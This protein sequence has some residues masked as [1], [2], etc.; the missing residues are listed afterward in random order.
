MLS[1]N[2]ERFQLSYPRFLAYS[3]LNSA[4]PFFC[5]PVNRIKQRLLS[6]IAIKYVQLSLT[7]ECQ[8][9]CSHCGVS[10]YSKANN[11]LTPEEI[12]SL[13][14][15][16]VRWGF[17]Q[18]DFFGGEP[19]LDKNISAY[20][21]RAS[22][23]GV[24]THLFTNGLLLSRENAHKLSGSGLSAISISF[25]SPDPA[26]HDRNRNIP[27]IFEKA[28]K[29]AQYCIQNKI[30]TIMSVHAS[31]SD[32]L[33]GQTEQLVKLAKEKGFRSIRILSPFKTGRFFSLNTPVY[34]E[35]AMR[36][37]LE[38]AGD[39]EFIQLH[40][41]ASCYVPYKTVAYISPY[42]EVQPCSMVPLKFGSI[43]KESFA[44]ILDRMRKHPVCNIN[45]PGCVMNTAYF[46][47]NF[48]AKINIKERSFPIPVE[49]LVFPPGTG[50]PSQKG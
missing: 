3:A 46:K 11:K 26:L 14:D 25:D 13:I 12:F 50:S 28:L 43:R 22:K 40:G 32:I 47:D 19:L 29:G 4:F 34:S 7:Y 49:Q 8:C 45:E 41:V 24:F 21:K 23:N 18:I 6:P 15:N 10:Q 2:K 17:G 30:K 48:F 27:G 31:E 16:L 20:I 42:G 35:K 37:L 36:R 5:P 39:K 38:I 1:D 9:S 33:S 44:S